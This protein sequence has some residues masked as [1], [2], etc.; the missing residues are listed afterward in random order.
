[1]NGGRNLRGRLTTTMF[2]IATRRALADYLRMVALVMFILLMVAWTIDLSEHF[3]AIRAAADADTV[4]LYRLL[5]PYLTYRAVDIITRLLPMA[6]LF[7][8]LVAEILRRMRS[9]SIV[10]AASGATPVRMLASVLWLGLILGTVQGMMEARWRPAAV[11]AQ[12]DLGL[13]DYARR[14]RRDWL[15]GASWF[16]EDNTAMRAEARR[17]DMPQLRNVLVF[18]GI[19]K[20]R[21]ETV[22][23]AERA[24]PTDEPSKWLLQSVRIWNPAREDTPIAILPSL[25]LDFDLIPEQLSYLHV[26]E[27]NIPTGPLM[28]IAARPD[29][30]NADAIQTAVWRRRTAWLIP[31]AVAMLAVALVR[32]GFLGR[33]PVIPRLIAV[34]AVGY[35]AVVSL[36]VFWAL[37]ELGTLPAPVSVLTTIALLPALAVV[38]ARRRA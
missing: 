26:A 28:R 31:G 20:P 21:L 38:I 8:V 13:G 16:I 33:V 37:G 30:P 12:V 3:P 1:M 9:E 25:V 27:F 18:Q 19:R 2:G 4:P 14:Y 22:I 17:T 32:A 7:G 29:A 36:K 6:C 24:Q 10:L 15:G 23:A 35:I 11:L 34:G 5:A